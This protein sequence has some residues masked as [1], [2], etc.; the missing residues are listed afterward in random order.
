MPSGLSITRMWHLPLRR[1]SVARRAGPR[2]LFVPTKVQWPKVAGPS[3][4]G[5]VANLTDMDG[6]AQVAGDR[7]PHAPDV[8]VMVA[9]E[10]A[11]G[12]RLQR[13]SCGICRRGWWESNGCFIGLDEAVEKMRELARELHARRLPGQAQDVGLGAAKLRPQSV[14]VRDGWKRAHL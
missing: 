1:G 10:G 14:P 9:F 2:A 8:T 11:R 4:L 6:A 5:L 13:F 7:C 12:E 3:T